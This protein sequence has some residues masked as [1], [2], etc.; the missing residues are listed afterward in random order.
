MRGRQLTILSIAIAGLGGASMGALPAYSQQGPAQS[1]PAKSIKTGAAKAVPK[2]KARPKARPAAKPSDA[3][4]SQAVD[5]VASLDKARR[6]LKDGKA[7][8]AL[9]LAGAVLNATGKDA[10]STARALAVRGEAHLLQNRPADALADLDSALWVKGG[11][12]GAERDA[13]SKA[14]SQALVLAGAPPGSAPVRQTAAAP[15]PVERIAV[16]SAAVPVTP[17]RQPI[18]QR[19]ESPRPATRAA[20][21]EPSPATRS[22]TWQVTA[23]PHDA[24]STRLNAAAVP[25]ERRPPAP[26]RTTA[27]V[28]TE[29]S[30][31]P[32]A[33]TG[34]GGFFANLFGGASSPTP[35]TTSSIP[36]PPAAALSSSPPQR[37][38][39]PVTGDRQRGSVPATVAAV[40]APPRAAVPPAPAPRAALPEPRET[41]TAARPQSSLGG[42]GGYRLQL[43]AVRSKSEAQSMAD[44]VRA[45]H[46]Q[47]ISN[48]SIEIDEAVYGN[49]GRF[50][51]VRIG[52]FASPTETQSLCAAM[53]N[54]GVDCMVLGP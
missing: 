36:Q 18:G 15:V 22:S 35:E 9:S 47:V 20:I 2:A 19:T 4:E 34:L 1:S 26:P 25:S 27:V 43:G 11:L 23:T 45:E 33:S 49:M 42:D 7:D 37:T 38:P 50:Y 24:S 40:Q 16:P 12:M 17:V 13:A 14:R 48:R 32:Q 54:S 8:V 6:A 10:R 52:G 31:T 41:S 51:R 53:R 39:P 30:S 3:G 21:A 44:R 29:A 5:A 28:A 46:G